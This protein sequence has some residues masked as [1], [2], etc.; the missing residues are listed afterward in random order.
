MELHDGG[1]GKM[2]EINRIALA[3]GLGGGLDIVNASILR[4]CAR[5]NRPMLGSVHPL[6]LDTA[7]SGGRRFAPAGMLL[8]AE[9]HIDY[10]S[11]SNLSRFPEARVA[12]VLGE[13]VVLLSRAIGGDWDEKI[14]NLSTSIEIFE[15]MHPGISFF[16]DGGGDSLILREQDGNET[17]EHSDPFRGGDAA[18]LQALSGTNAIMG[19][20]GVGLDIDSTAFAEN[21]E[22]LAVLDAYHGRINLWTGAVEG[23]VFPELF[24]FSKTN[25]E[26]YLEFAG[27]ILVLEEADLENPARTLSHIAT[28]VYPALRGDRG[29]HRTFLPWEPMT[30]NGPGV[31]VT[32]EHAW[33]YFVDAGAVHPL[34]LKL[35]GC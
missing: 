32:D 22:R 29:L 33:L 12:T 18:T 31:V 1:I 15:E 10:V 14:A 2:S 4:F 20:I 35:N 5:G 24:D 26:D 6:P 7:V 34:K 17:S 28:V 27:R 13:E 19:I 16:M 21:I 30:E 3:S 23:N 9:S 25:L 8:N 11:S